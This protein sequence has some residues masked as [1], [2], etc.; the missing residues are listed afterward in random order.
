[1][2]THFII[3]L[4]RAFKWQENSKLEPVSQLFSLEKGSLLN[5]LHL[6]EIV[7]HLRRFA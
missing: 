2:I 4:D 3:C 1:M 7:V 5:A 6:R